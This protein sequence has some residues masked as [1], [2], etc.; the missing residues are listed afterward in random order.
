MF[1]TQGGLQSA[2]E[3]IVKGV[4]VVG[5][6][7]IADQPANVQAMVKQGL[8]LKL[9]SETLTKDRLK[10]AIIEVAQNEKLVY[11]YESCFAFHSKFSHNQIFFCRYKQAVLKAKRIL[12]D[13][14]LKGLD[15]AIWWIEYVLRHG[16]V[17]HLR[18]SA[19]DMS[20]VEYLMLD[21]IIFLVIALAVIIYSLRKLFSILQKCLP[22]KKKI[23]TH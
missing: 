12:E 18:S 10:E 8:G 23:K 9:D 21:V 14:P 5:I 22:T 11:F 2:E 1:V 4:P 20:F 15:K 7:F 13:Q 3:A 16:D 19:A 6:P 17:R